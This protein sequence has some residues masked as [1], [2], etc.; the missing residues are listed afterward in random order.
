MQRMFKYIFGPVLSS[1]L[2]R[3][4][5][6]DLLGDRICSFDCLYCE[7][8]PTHS[9]TLH[10]APYVHKDRVLQELETWL[11]LDDH[12]EIDCI[13]LGGEGEP[14]LNL[15]LGQII[16]GIKNMVPEIPVAV[17][18]N[19]SLLFSS[20]V[21]KELGAADVVL[22]SLDTLM[23]REFARL[24]RPC[25]GLDIGSLAQNLTRF[26]Q[27]FS[28]R[29]Y[30]EILLVPGVNDSQENLEKMQEFLRD[31]KRDRVDITCMSR[32][33]AHM[34][35][36]VPDPDVLH[37]WRSFLQI[38]PQDNPAGLFNHGQGEKRKVNTGCILDSLRRRPQTREQLCAALGLDPGE[39]AAILDN[40]QASGLIQ[41][42]QERDQKFYTSKG[43]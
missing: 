29:I 43:F 5:G 23:P 35:P 12:P 34:Q 25:T 4:L 38:D 13:T 24:N 33:G 16:E 20:E 31:F 26:C 8:G 30:L 21:R 37:K 36:A 9:Q 1:R 32:P 27:G 15:H 39:T 2:G 7:C 40:L 42:I 22:P 6:V 11:A 19:S 17:L 10:R 18:T 14:C 3:S 28:G 41:A